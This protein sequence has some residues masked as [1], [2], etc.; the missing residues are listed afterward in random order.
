M[1][2]RH[3]LLKDVQGF[4]AV[5]EVKSV[6]NKMT[7]G[8][9]YSTVNILRG[10]LVEEYA[11]SELNFNMR[12]CRD[13]TICMYLSLDS[14]APLSAEEFL[15]LEGIQLISDRF[16]TFCNGGIELGMVLVPGSKVY[17]EVYEAGHVKHARATVQ[18]KGKVRGLPG[19]TFGIEIKVR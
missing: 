5:G 8:E 11:M 1:A 2:C 16:A 13:P 19:T 3:I 10:E 15:L 7:G 14:L 4:K 12:L 6:I 18:F 17:V 9:L